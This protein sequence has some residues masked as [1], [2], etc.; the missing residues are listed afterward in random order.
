VRYRARL[1]GPKTDGEIPL[2]VS[3]GSPVFRV[4]LDGAAFAGDAVAWRPGIWSLVFEDG[5][6]IEVSLEPGGEG[7][8]RARFGN[9]AVTFELQDEL[10]ALALASAGRGKSKKGDVVT[11]AMPGRVLR[12]SV[13]P[14][15][16]IQ[17]G[18]SL[19]VLEAMKMENEVKAPR[20]GV[21]DTI[22]V[23]AG[24]AVSAGE[25]LVRLRPEG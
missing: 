14:G 18:Q 22:G 10:T 6:Q 5:R 23:A 24:Q 16:A 12:V 13:A 8:L 11:A 7:L 3:R 25:V 15:E 19:L 21:V 1:H 9:A 20:D 2:E 17:S 4:T